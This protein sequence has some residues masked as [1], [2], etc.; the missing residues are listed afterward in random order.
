VATRNGDAVAYLGGTVDD[1]WAT[2]G[3]GGV[4]ASEPE[5]VRDVFAA[6]AERWGAA[7]FTVFVPA[8]ERETVDAFFRLAFGCQA[9]L[10]VQ[11]AMPA[12]PVDFG[13]TIRAARPEDV[14]TLAE[15]ER[16]LWELQVE[17]PSYSG[18]AL[19]TIEEHIEGWGELFDPPDVHWAF[20]AE[21]DDSPVGG[22]VMYRRPVGDLR[23]PE[24]NIDLAFAATRPEVR[25]SGAGLALTNHVIAWAHER[26]FRS[27]TVDWRVVNLFSSR[28]WP[29]RGFR[30]QYLRLYRA[31]P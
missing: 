27:V 4:A 1:G 8:S 20:I 15:L 5:A 6:M 9:T 13:G 14:P 26:G 24:S 29:R 25:G 28:F 30:S 22:V 31:V 23:V 10:A 11:E 21:R 12:A 3:Q 19:P 17:P 18:V 7:R 2:M 16:V